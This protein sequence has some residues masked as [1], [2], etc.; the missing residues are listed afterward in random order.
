MEVLDRRPSDLDDDWPDRM[1]V[2]DT[3]GRNADGRVFT[4]LA[5][6]GAH[7]PIRLG[8]GFATITVRLSVVASCDESGLEEMAKQFG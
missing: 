2:N 6:I 8:P 4:L 5:N 1:V 3:L 7:R